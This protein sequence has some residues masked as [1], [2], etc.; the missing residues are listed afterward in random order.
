MRIGVVNDL[1]GQR[2]TSTPW[3]STAVAGSSLKMRPALDALEWL[4]RLGVRR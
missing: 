2:V 1:P 3:R 4:G